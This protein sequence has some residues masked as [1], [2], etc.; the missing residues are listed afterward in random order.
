MWPPK[1]SLDPEELEVTKVTL[2]G[3]VKILSSLKEI[4]DDMGVFGEAKGARLKAFQSHVLRLYQDMLD[5]EESTRLSLVKKI[6]E[7][8]HDLRKLNKELSGEVTSLPE[9]D[10]DKA[11]LYQVEKS[12]RDKWERLQRLKVERLEQLE[13]LQKRHD[14]VRY[15][16]GKKD[17]SPYPG[18][19][20]QLD[21]DSLRCRVE[22][23]EKE[24]DRLQDSF[25]ETQTAIKRIVEELGITCSL[26]FENM[27][28]STPPRSF[29][30]SS[31]NMQGVKKMYQTFE[32]KLSDAKATATELRECLSN[33]WE[34]LHI[35]GVHRE[36]FLNAHPGYSIPTINALKKELKRCEALKRAN[37]E[38]FVL[39]LREEVLSWWDRCHFSQNERDKFSAFRYAEF[40]EDVLEL[41]EMEVVKLRNYYEGHRDIFQLA[42]QRND[43]WSKVLE[44]E[45][46]ANDPNRLFN[47]RG[48]QLLREERERNALSK[49]LPKIEKELRDRLL[50]YE[51]ENNAPF[52]YD[53]ENL[54]EI[55]DQQT[56]ERQGL[57]ELQKQQKRVT[58]NQQLEVESK[59]G[60]KATTPT[61]T[62]RGRLAP[63]TPSMLGSHQKTLTLVPRSAP[64]RTLGSALKRK[65]DLSPHVNVSKKSKGGRKSSEKK[66]S[67]SGNKSGPRYSTSKIRRFG[68]GVCK[69]TEPTSSKTRRNIMSGIPADNSSIAVGPYSEFQ[70]QLEMMSMEKACRSSVV[71]KNCLR[72]Y[73]TPVTAAS[74]TKLILTPGKITT[75]THLTVTPG[76]LGSF[77]ATPMKP[78]RRNGVSATPTPN[79]QV[80]RTS[81][82]LNLKSPSLKSPSSGNSAR[83]TT[84]RSRL[85]I[86]F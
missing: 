24:R 51:L 1:A 7:H 17:L 67:R 38:K 43:L 68:K 74:T 57:K 12:L 22:S 79:S 72:E 53:G 44:L 8:L 18:G 6:E 86:V 65:A 81:T 25:E 32:Q 49:A 27:V 64:S 42:D 29:I 76:T 62:R 52:F 85:P 70:D 2:D 69:S 4:W 66:S 34:R 84:P 9:E 59:L 28:L 33:L 39:E 37:I 15:R 21:I 30:L 36:A 75:A 26:A 11:P 41:H 83:L 35:S 23:L 47:N 58:R 77:S 40:T 56:E 10:C 20:S 50:E 63:P 82:R 46:R 45:G 78:P 60:T 13:D 14:E 5:E 61:S 48:G 80:R 3:T 73:N 54:L 19:I 16:L 55:I 31:E 71:P